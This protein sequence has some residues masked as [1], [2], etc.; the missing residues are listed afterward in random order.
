MHP[1]CLVDRHNPAL[2]RRLRTR[3]ENQPRGR[4]V[5]AQPYDILLHLSHLLTA[6][7]SHLGRTIYIQPVVIPSST[8]LAHSRVSPHRSLQLILT[9]GESAADLNVKPIN[10]TRS[11]LPRARPPAWLLSSL[12]FP[13]IQILPLQWGRIWRKSHLDALNRCPSSPSL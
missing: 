12:L 10:T 11:P 8:T 9:S 1:P 13:G 4:H 5:F 7:M 6:H 2:H 3:R